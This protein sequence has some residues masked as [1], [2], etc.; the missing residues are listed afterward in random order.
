[1]II[2]GGEKKVPHVLAQ[3]C[4][5]QFPDEIV[6]VMRSGG[7]CMVHA[8]NCK[9]LNR[10]NPARLLPAYWSAHD[11]GIIVSLTLVAYDRPGLI[12]DITQAFYQAG[13]NIVEMHTNDLEKGMC[14]IATRIGIPSDE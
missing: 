8:S 4:G 6:A 13:V 11:T 14:E 7:K 9:S 3:C 1:M 10:V 12:A 2:I 5:P